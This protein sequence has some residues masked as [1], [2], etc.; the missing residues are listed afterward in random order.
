[1]TRA[2]SATPSTGAT[3]TCPERFTLSSHRTPLP[4][5]SI[6]GVR[7]AM[8]LHKSV[9]FDS[10]VRR[11]ASALAAA[12]HEVTVL[13]LAP[14]PGEGRLEGFTRRSVLPPAWLRARLPFHLYRA[15]FLWCFVVGIRRARP[16]VVHAHDAA[17]LLPG[18]IGARLTGA[19]L[20]YD[21]HELATSVPYRERLWA[22]FVGAIER[23]VVP[24][25]T[26][27]ITVS[28]GIAQRLQARYELARTP[29]VARNVSALSADGRPGL[30]AALGLGA[31]VPLVLHQGAPAPA[32]GC[33]V[34]IDAVARLPGVHLAFL[35][36]ADPGYAAGLR[37]LIAQRGLLERVTLLP[38]VPLEDLLA[39]TAEANVGVTLLQDTCLNHRLALPNKLFEYIAAGVPVVAADLPET[40]R[41]VERHGVG[42][43]VSPS[44]PAALTQALRVAL[45]GPRDPVLDERLA[46][47][48]EELCWAREQE[49]LLNLY[50]R[51]PQFTSSPRP[52]RVLLLTHYYP[53]EVGAA[54][55][56]I[57][58]LARGLAGRGME[59]TVHTGFP[60]YPS[61]VL[62]RPYRNRLVQVEWQSGVR[63]V[64][65]LVYPTPNAG[66]ARRLANHAVF[67]AGALATYAASGPVDVVVAETPPLFTAF[68]GVLYAKLKRAPLALNVSDLWPESAIELGVLGDGLAARAAHAL[69]RRC[70]RSARLITAPTQGIVESLG[71]RSEAR[72][73]VVQVPPAVDLARFTALAPLALRS[74]APLRVLYAGTLGLAQG[75]GTLVEAAALA[76]PTVVELLLTGDGPAAA[77]LRREVAARGLAHVRLLGSVA[78]ERVPSLYAEADAGV[79]PLRD[80]PIFNGAL[81]TKLFEVLAAGRP[82][83]V[84]AHGEAAELVR[85]SGAGLAVAPEDPLALAEAFRRLHA[86]PLEAGAMGERG[87]L[88][89]ARFDRS[90]AVGLW[91]QLLNGL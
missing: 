32:R 14:V 82:A 40:R 64:R 47:A 7:V 53:P 25:C 45:H 83:V 9:Q 75:L 38:S 36:D 22:W 76:G 35:G 69:A 88:H 44:D 39:H 89:A 58:A 28:D 55:A 16:D 11:E 70:Y 46:R 10:R 74:G 24:R 91:E 18:I 71:A 68:A 6:G 26:A 52:M 65:S 54:P 43:C 20:V 13:E 4:A 62:A 79:V 78:P 33:E 30:R 81:P 84:A 57:A 50:T 56:R 34:L 21:S 86:D 5:A 1:L 27:V 2:S 41:L 23:L 90:A 8:L 17:M 67:A 80:L 49:R 19:G 73:K 66:F 51:L 77:P 59:V 48:G 85:S 60:H 31:E 37:E 72:G 15:A 12:G 3:A 87:R 29:T 42:W 63:V 61:G